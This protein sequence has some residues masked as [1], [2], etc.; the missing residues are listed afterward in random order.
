M[1]DEYNTAKVELIRD[2]PIE[3][4]EF[5][6]LFKFEEKIDFFLFF[7][8]LD[9]FQLNRNTYNRVRHWF[10]HLDAYRKTLIIRQLE[11]YPPC[12]DLTEGSSN[13]LSLLDFSKI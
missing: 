5:D 13:N 4:H 9:L 12:D 1:R 2:H 3:Q 10:D 11:E 8:I 6:G 7:L